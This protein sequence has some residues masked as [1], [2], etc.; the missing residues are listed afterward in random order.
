[1]PA[2]GSLGSKRTPRRTS[3][4]GAGPSVVVSYAHEDRQFVLGLADALHQR[5][6][7]VWVDEGEMRVGDVLID[8]IASAIDEMEFLLAIVSEASV[9]SSWC[10]RELSIAISGALE[11]AKVKVLPVR[12]GRTALPPTLRG[13]YSPRVDPAA[14]DET[15]E[16]LVADM[17]SHKSDRPKPRLSR[18]APRVRPAGDVEP[19]QSSRSRSASTTPTN[20]DE[21]IRI[22]GIDESGVTQPRNDGTRGSGL[23]MVPLRLNQTPP[24]PWGQVFRV[25]WDHPPQFTTMHRPGI[26]SVS[27]DRII[28]DGT[29]V[30]EVERYHAETLR[31]VIPEVN[32]QL[33][34]LEAAKQAQEAREESERRVHEEGVREAAKRVSFE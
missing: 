29:T 12:L 22:L 9:Q 15:A 7:R 23:Y 19:S 20:P 27:G 25:V 14:I 13:I 17:R 34:E 26:A 21:P 8:R 32:R 16:K 30:E 3:A 33:A 4:T 6:C 2:S 31:H 18:T 28:L 5:G 10:Q 11:Q 1:M 24:G